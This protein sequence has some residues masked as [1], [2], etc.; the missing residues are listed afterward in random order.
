MRQEIIGVFVLLDHFTEP[1]VHIPLVWHLPWASM[2]L[3]RSPWT[4]GV[5]MTIVP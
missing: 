3:P 4:V 1:D 2:G 5:T